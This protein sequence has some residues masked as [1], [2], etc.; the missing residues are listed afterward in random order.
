MSCWRRSRPMDELVAKFF[1]Y[2]GVAGVLGVVWFLEH[3]RANAAQTKSDERA[4]Q[5]ATM[6]VSQVES[7]S[8]VAAALTSLA[9]EVRRP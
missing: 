2:G 7:N 5:M 3:K 1:D 6:M 9:T 8:N 4:D